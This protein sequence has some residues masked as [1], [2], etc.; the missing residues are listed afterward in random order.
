MARIKSTIDKDYVCERL[1]NS[2]EFRQIRITQKFERLGW[3]C[4]FDWCED[5]TQRVYLKAV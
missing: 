1:V 3:E 2:E 5:A 4:V